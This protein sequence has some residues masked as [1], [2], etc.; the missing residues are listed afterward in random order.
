MY[1][2]ILLY[3][4]NGKIIFSWI[5]VKGLES[6]NEKQTISRL[7]KISQ[8]NIYH[9]FY[10]SHFSGEI[11][12]G[13]SPHAASIYKYFFESNI[14]CCRRVCPLGLEKGPLETV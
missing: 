8:Q 3:K 10:N 12:G 6:D 7:R 2:L 14:F 11:W 5:Q 4:S 9:I 13:H 1:H